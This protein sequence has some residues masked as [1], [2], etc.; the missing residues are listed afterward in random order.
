MLT[1]VKRDTGPTA[2]LG[3]ADEADLIARCRADE[4]AAHEELYHRFRRPVAA[5]L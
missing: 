5:N 4:R 2:A 1:A 3:P